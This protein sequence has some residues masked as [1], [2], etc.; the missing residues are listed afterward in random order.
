MIIGQVAFGVLL[1]QQISC[2]ADA[3]VLCGSFFTY[4]SNS[5]LW[6]PYSRVSSSLSQITQDLVIFLT[7]TKTTYEA[8]TPIHNLSFF[9]SSF[10]FFFFPWLHSPA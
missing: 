4:V 3:R 2:D 8:V 1:I 7:A 10:F 6:M 9:I 5:Q